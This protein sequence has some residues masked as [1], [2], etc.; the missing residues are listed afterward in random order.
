MHKIEEYLAHAEECRRLAT[1]TYEP[2]HK[3]ALLRM[4][5]TW[6]DLAIA[7]QRE[8][9]RIKRIQDLETSNKLPD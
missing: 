8:N 1:S 2:A 7:R 5:Q 4:A 3:D 6:N 9:E